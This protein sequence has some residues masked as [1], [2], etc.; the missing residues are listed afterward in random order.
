MQLINWHNLK[1]KELASMNLN[2]KFTLFVLVIGCSLINVYAEE[3]TKLEQKEALAKVDVII[4]V[5]PLD[6]ELTINDYPQILK[7][8][9]PE[10]SPQ[11]TVIAGELSSVDIS[12]KELNWKASGST[13]IKFVTN[14]NASEFNLEFEIVS[15]KV[16]NI[17]SVA[18][19]EIGKV[20]LMSA[21]LDNVTKLIRVTTA[22]QSNSANNNDG[23][24][25]S[26]P[27][28]TSED[29][30]MV[31]TNPN[32]CA[33]ISV[34]KG[35]SNKH[36]KPLRYITHNGEDLTYHHSGSYIHANGK[37]LRI[38][39]GLHE[40]TATADCRPLSK[41]MQ[42]TKSISGSTRNWCY[43]ASVKKRKDKEFR[44]EF[45]FS[46]NV[47]AGKR[48]HIVAQRKMLSETELEHKLSANVYKV[49]DE[50]CSLSDYE[51]NIK[52]TRVNR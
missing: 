40:F 22:R 4:D 18:S 46:I 12:N 49:T 2:I 37:T 20:M 15:E 26:K 3:N 9:K 7:N 14:A 51:K 1:I 34:S 47:E 17:A 50:S 33:T 10:S 31:E 36:V 28:P 27:L 39:P 32:Y 52:G 29:T 24:L 44:G 5:F 30:A 42:R 35:P 21:N 23:L 13:R 6:G 19:M 38:K 41:A 45:A 8:N 11:F 16:N 43:A 48:Y 25:A